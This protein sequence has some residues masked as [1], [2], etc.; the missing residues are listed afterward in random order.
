VNYPTISVLGQ[1]KKPDL[2]KMRHRITL[3]DAIAISGGFTEFAKR[4]K[5]I[6]YRN[7]TN[8]PQKMEINLKRLNEENGKIYLQ[9]FDT[10]YVE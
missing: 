6:V 10:V 4:D 9:P 8:P 2:Y 1:V 5:V 3:L 7:S